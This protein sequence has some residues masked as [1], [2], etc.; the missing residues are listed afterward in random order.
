MFVDNNLN[1]I[2]FKNSDKLSLFFEYKSFKD[3]SNYIN[4]IKISDSKKKLIVFFCVDL[5]KGQ[6]ISKY[7]INELSDKFIFKIDENIPDYLIYNVF[8]NYHL[9]KKWK[10]CIKIAYFTE[11]KIPDLNEADYAISFYH[12]NYLDRF[13]KKKIIFPIINIK[14]IRDEVIK[15]KNRKKF[16]AAVISNS[17]SKFR[18]NFIKELSKY[19][20]V[21]MW[22][23]FKNNIGGKVKNKT[24]FLS[25]Y[26][27]SIAME[28]SEGDGYTSEK[29]YQSYISGTIPIYY[30]NY[31]I[32]EIFNPKSYI[33]IKGEKDMQKKIEYIK[34]IDNDDNL[35]INMLKENIYIDKYNQ[36]DK[37]L[38][39]FYYN[40]FSQ[41]KLK[42]FRKNN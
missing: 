31:M 15:S 16:C 39:S 3:I 22:G 41:E 24:L 26:K 36:I 42:A 10:N 40:I 25:S 33:L 1:Y 4:K 2:L 18:I 20:K 30:G 5:Y 27:F 35:Y 17:K 34:R 9:N 21:D 19:K 12:I 32:D 23:R 13:F 14:R 7:I 11:N 6:N 8:G 28:N 29:I 37:E 38:K